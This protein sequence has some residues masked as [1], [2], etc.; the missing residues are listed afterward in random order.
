MPATEYKP[1]T[2]TFG[3]KGVNL[4]SVADELQAEQFNAL[5][6]WVTDREGSIRSRY[7]NTLL[8]TAGALSSLDV[9]T[10]WRLKGTSASYRYAGANDKLFRAATPF[11]TYT[12]ILPGATWLAS[13]TYKVGDLVVPTVANGHFFNCTTAGTSGGAEPTWATGA[14]ATTTDNT[15]TWTESN[16]DGNAM[17]PEDYAVGIDTKPWTFFSNASAFIK[18]S[19]TGNP[20]LV[21]LVAP[22]TAPTLAVNAYAAKTIQDF[23]DFTQWTKTDPSAILT[24]SNE[25][26]IKKVGTNSLKC[27][28]SGSGS[29][30]ITINTALDLTTFTGGAAAT[31]SDYIHIWMYG[32]SPANI[33]ALQLQFSLGDTTFNEHYEKTITPSLVQGGVNLA[34][35]PSTTNPTAFQANLFGNYF[36]ANGTLINASTGLPLID[37]STGLPVNAT[38]LQN[39]QPATL[40]AGSSVWTDISVMK[41]DFLDTLGT[42]STNTYANVQAIRIRMQVSA[43]TNIYL[44]DWLLRGGGQL[45]GN[46]YLWKYLYRNSVTGSISNPSPVSAAPATFP[47]RNTVTVTVNYSRDPQVDTID[48]YRIGGTAT[49]YALSGSVTNTPSAA[50]ATTTYTD[51]IGDAFLTTIIQIDNQRPLNFA[52]LALHQ[53]TLFGWGAPGDPPNAVRF[54]KRVN[55]EQW[56]AANL[57]YVGSGADKVVRVVSNGEQLFAATLSQ[58]FRIIG[59]DASSYQP[60]S[61]GFNRGMIDNMLALAVSPGSQSLVA[62]D[63]IYSFPDGRKLTQPIDGVVHGLTI[64]GISPV[65]TAQLGKIVMAFYDNKI[66]VDYPSGSA[67]NNDTEMV[68]DVLYQRWESSTQAARSI[69]AEKASN[70]LVIGKTDGNIYQIEKGSTDNGSAIAVTMWSDF[71]HL[72]AP[73]QDKIFSDFAL[74]IDTAGQNV[75]VQMV[76]NNGDIT[77]TVQTVNT[78]SRSLTQVAIFS[79]A[80][81]KAL[82]AQLRVTGS[83]SST[84]T[85]YKA[86]F[87]VVVEPPARSAFQTEWVDKDYPYDKYIK[88]IL[89]EIDTLGLSATVHLDVDNVNDVVTAFTVNKGGRGR[90]TLSVPRDTI[91]KIMRLRITGNP[92]KLYNFD[93]VVQPEPPDVT[94]ADSLEQLFGFPRYKFVKR[95]WIALKAPSAVSMAVYADEVLKTTETIAATNLASGWQKVLV[96]LPD[97]IKGKYFR[98]VF[99]S[100]SAFKIYWLDSEAEF[101][102]I[103]SEFGYRVNHF[104]PPQLM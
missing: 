22:A 101:K 84:I 17:L 28:F 63:G 94:I 72:G 81:Q 2:V 85:L 67:T 99:T 86:I 75:S 55:V 41:S 57:L 68:F 89:L 66:H 82:N 90:I 50:G 5:T 100:S 87:Y 93:F 45:T 48:V 27:A 98:F 80:G 12:Q 29:A 102:P 3:N 18:D 7:G 21:G 10:L 52:G 34:A 37:P 23:E 95:A 1:V 6:N 30:Y 40:E 43:A 62:Y 103:N 91:G 74:D 97:K 54:S 92:V 73:G 44:D 65:N 70:V 36:I 53:E 79:G 33:T 61:T 56:P 64:N 42:G 9:H 19:G 76:F 14:G 20:S 4:R 46:N 11:T 58:V 49:S 38:D 83:Y 24:L 13:R 16:F 59:S 96:Q 47:T 77:D 26:T 25:G 60:L 32:D 78:A 71:M 15:V 35:T 104:A 8:N 88:E 31:T 51:N 39:F 69:L